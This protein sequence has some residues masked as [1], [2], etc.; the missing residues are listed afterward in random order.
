MLNDTDNE[1][2]CRIGPGTPMGEYLRRFWVPFL[3]PEELPEPDSPPVRTTLMGEELVAFKDTNGDIGLLD[4]Y[5]PHRRASLFFG[6]NEEC[7]LRC[8]YHGW[9]YDTEGNCIDMPSEPAESNFKDKVKIKAYPAREWGGLIWAYMGPVEFMP[10]LPK[11]D[12]ATLPDS[13]RVISKRVQES[14]WVQSVEGGIDSSHISFLHSG[15]TPFLRDNPDKRPARRGNGRPLGFTT[16]DTS[17][18]FAVDE[19][20]AGLLI[21]ARREADEDRYYYRITQMLLPFYT[22]IP[23]AIEPGHQV[24]GHAWVPIDDYSCWNFSISWNPY[25]PFTEEEVVEHWSGYGLHALTDHQYR[26]LSNSSNDYN[27]DREEQRYRTFT[28]IKGIGEQ[29]MGTQESMGAMSWRAGEHLGAS[30]SAII[31]YRRRLMKEVRNLQEGVESFAATHPDAY[32]VRSASVL[33]KRGESY[34]DAAKE[35]LNAK[36]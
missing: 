31:A 16:T 23:G 6:R 12:W 9:K 33:I 24:G 19:T 35:R 10:E 29:D 14:N 15:V 28:G 4:N 26:P 21:S 1:F 25:R 13:H 7:G 30:D 2:L 32:A 3:L 27:I 18:R 5:C 17:P 34:L 36:V 11:L 8:V 20:D 22:M